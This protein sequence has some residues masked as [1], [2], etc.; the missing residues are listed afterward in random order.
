MNNLLLPSVSDL[1]LTSYQAKVIHS[2]KYNQ[3]TG[4]YF[5]HIFFSNLYHDVA[6]K[7]EDTGEEYSTTIR[8][9]NLTLY[10]GQLVTL[11]AVNDIVVAYSD[12][13]REYYYLT[14][15][16]PTAL[17]YGVKISLIWMVLTL[18]LVVATLN[19]YNA[20]SSALVGVLLLIPIAVRVYQK[21]YDY[22]FTK[23]IDRLIIA[24]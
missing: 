10:S 17:G 2:N 8:N 23:R 21:L 9:L 5:S 4:F 20:F 24:S 7:L 15:N 6:F 3:N 19:W 11:Y 14:E 18:A 13:N 22:F 1:T 12:A 16:L